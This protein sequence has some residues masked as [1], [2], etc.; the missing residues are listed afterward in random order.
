MSL[1]T[2]HNTNEINDTNYTDGVVLNQKLWDASTV[3]TEAEIEALTD[4]KKQAYFEFYYEAVGIH[5]PMDFIVIEVDADD[6]RFEELHFDCESS[7]GI[8]RR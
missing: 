5:H 8:T 6:E 3:I 7:D 1:T 4:E 2:E